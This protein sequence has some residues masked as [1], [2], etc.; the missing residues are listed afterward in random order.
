MRVI[1]IASVCS[2]VAASLVGGVSQGAGAADGTSKACRSLAGLQDD[3]SEVGQEFDD[4]FDGEEF[5]EIGQA[6]TKAAKSAPKKVRSSLRTMAKFYRSIGD[7]DDG[8]DAARLLA[9]GAQRYGKA[10]GRFA[11]FLATECSGIGGSTS[12][13]GAGAGSGG[14]LVVAGQT[15]TLERS[16]C[17]LEE[18]VAA[19]QTIELT[20]QA[21][22]TTADGESV[23]IDFT[24]Y[25]QGGR[26]EGDDLSIDIGPVTQ[27]TTSYSGSLDYGAVDRSGSRLSASDVEVLD[28]S[29][30]STETVSFEIEC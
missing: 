29:S 28:Q 17:F 2:L 5:E 15:V 10:A 26:F 23:T 3:L 13:S 21:F 27:P 16:L 22:G 25:A 8:A 24:R 20:A 19:G 18:Q 12:G 6:F 14:E 11:E 1:R 4:A 9:Q 7:A 30:G